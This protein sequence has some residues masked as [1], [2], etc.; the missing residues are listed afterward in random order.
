MIRSPDANWRSPRGLD[1]RIV[2]QIAC[3]TRLGT[4]HQVEFANLVIG[5]SEDDPAGRRITLPRA[6]PSL[7]QRLACGLAGAGQV[8]H[9]VLVIG[10]DR[11]LGPVRREAAR[12]IALPA[13]MLTPDLCDFDPAVAL[14]ES[15]ESGPGFDRLELLRIADQ[16]H[17]GACIGCAGEDALHLPGANHP[18]L[19]D[20]QHIARIE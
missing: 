2:A 14:M 15:T 1:G 10:P 18:G 7:D 9:A 20:H 12:G 8:D 6:I 17:L 11:F 5:V 13:I 19:V 4:R 3:P 16:H